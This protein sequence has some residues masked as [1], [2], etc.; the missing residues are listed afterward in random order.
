MSSEQQYKQISQAPSLQ[1]SPQVFLTGI[2]MLTWGEAASAKLASCTWLLDL[3][4]LHSGVPRLL[5][6]RTV[7]WAHTQLHKTWGYISPI[8]PKVASLPWG[9]QVLIL[10]MTSSDHPCWC[11]A[12]PL[13]SIT[14]GKYWLE[15]EPEFSTVRQSPEGTTSST[16][17]NTCL[18]PSWC[19][20]WTILLPH[21]CS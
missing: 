3:R 20:Q 18:K 12:G 2:S 5:S 1:T 13:F 8:S 17:G 21:A 7:K 6:Q 14:M 4:P 11:T 16:P 19:D 10:S 9:F 15:E